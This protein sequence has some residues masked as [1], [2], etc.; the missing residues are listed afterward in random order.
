MPDHRQRP[1]LLLEAQKVVH[2]SINHPAVK[3]CG[4]QKAF[5]Q[6]STI[7]GKAFNDRLQALQFH[8]THVKQ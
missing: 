4:V 5:P 3:G 2:K 1:L 6:I 7:R 8:T